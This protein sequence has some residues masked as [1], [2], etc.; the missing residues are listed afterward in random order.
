[1]E[2][3]SILKKKNKILII[4]GVVVIIISC[5]ILFLILNKKFIK[6]GIKYV[7]DDGTVWVNFKNDGT[8]ERSIN[9][10]TCTYKIDKKT[11][12]L[13]ETKKIGNSSLEI[14][15]KFEI[16]N[17]EELKHFY[18]CI[19]G[20]ENTIYSCNGTPNVDNRYSI[21]NKISE[22][23]DD[24]EENS[25][26]EELTIIDTR[27]MH[28]DD[29]YYYACYSNDSKERILFA[30]Y[31]NG[32]Y[33]LVY[34]KL[35]MSITSA[36]YEDEETM[37]GTYRATDDAIY[38]GNQVMP[39]I[40]GPKAGIK[41]EVFEFGNIQCILKDGNFSE[42][43][44]NTLS[45]ENATNNE[46]VNTDSNIDIDDN[47]K[48]VDNTVNN[49]DD[50]TETKDDIGTQEE[51][52]QKS[53]EALDKVELEL[54]HVRSNIYGVKLN[55]YDFN[56]FNIMI[57]NK[58]Y[59]PKDNIELTYD[60]V[61]KN[62]AD[63]TLT[64]V[65]QNTKTYNKCLNFVSA[66]LNYKTWRY[67]LA[68]NG[69]CEMVLSNNDDSPEADYNN[70]DLICTLNGKDHECYNGLSF[71][72]SMGTYTMTIKNKYGETQNI[73]VYCGK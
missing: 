62:C 26:D 1:M 49:S 66:P 22:K 24:L 65:Y 20:F 73:E 7:N 50:N 28:F 47:E 27:M 52:A 39:I 70:N 10:D 31:E 18:T 21:N 63:I 17:N 29:K 6:Y 54:T 12:T 46:D 11:I 68:P 34:S 67:D 13:N 71:E 44:D 45:D 16:I 25:S 43:N 14:E 15:M 36:K 32:N 19:P 4:L 8:C 57:N 56:D 55:T 64:D 58:K 51:L 30:F 72:V 2:K 23:Q 59:R 9:A 5:L 37:E 48:E 41:T 53:K 3:R 35:K 61:G 42:N 38:I 40:F 60:H 69:Y 33:K